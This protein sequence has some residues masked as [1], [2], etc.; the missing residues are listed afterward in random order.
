[1][2]PTVDPCRAV[3]GCAA[4]YEAGL[5]ADLDGDV[6]NPEAPPSPAT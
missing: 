1:V 3:P 5:L 4:P 6:V 2:V